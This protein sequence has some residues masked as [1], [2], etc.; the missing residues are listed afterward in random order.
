YASAPPCPSPRLCRCLKSPP[1]W[2][3]SP[4]LR[5]HR[6]PSHGIVLR[7]NGPLQV[8][9]F[10][11]V[12]R[13]MPSEHAVDLLV[14]LDR[15]AAAE[16]L[17]RQLYAQ[18]RDAILS[19]RLRAGERLPPTRELARELGVARLTVAM[20][21]DWLRAEGFVFGRVGAG[22][23]VAPAFGESRSPLDASPAGPAG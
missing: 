23:F 9:T 5:L 21:Y 2:P 6:T 13:P 10:E 4:A 1:R 11:R 8:P 16:G 19:G 12:D 7:W 17:T 15:S 3:C 22:T 18:L 14:A 20:A